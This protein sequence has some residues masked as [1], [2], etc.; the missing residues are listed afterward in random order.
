MRIVVVYGAPMSGKTTYVNKVMQNTDIV[1][2]YNVLAKTIMNNHYRQHNDY[3]HKLLMD[4]R[5]KMIEHAKQS[6]SGTLYIITT[7]LSYTLKDNVETHF[8]TQYKQMDTSL[9]ECKRRLNSSGSHNKEHLMQVIHEW[10]GKYIYNKGLID[11]DELTKKTKDL[12]KGKDWMKLRTLALNRDNHLCQM[13]IR[14]SVF[15][16]ADLVHHIIYVKSD[17]SKALDLDN[18]MCVCSKCHNKIHSE[19]E[20]KV[21]VNANHNKN[22]RTIKI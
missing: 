11:S 9:L 1:F 8:N 10:Y 3:K 2:D 12:Y 5:N 4:I 14:N 16:P 13:C 19:D 18:L 6:P 20:E 22:I 15:T 17:F 21:F 7:Y